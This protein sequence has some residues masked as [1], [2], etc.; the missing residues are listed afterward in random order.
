MN[1]SKRIDKI[2]IGI[3]L[4]MFGVTILGTAINSEA[5]LGHMWGAVNSIYNSAGWFL[6][7]MTLIC[8]IFVLYFLFSRAGDIKIGGEDAEPEFSKVTWWSISLCAGMGMGIVFWPAAECIEYAVRPAAGAH[9]AAGSHAAYLWAEAQTLNH[10]VITLYA[11]Y[12]AV[13]VVAT[14]TYHNLKQPFSVTASLYPTFG[15]KVYKYRSVIDG[16]VT[17]ALVGGVAGSF[18]YGVMQVGNGLEQI[19][20]IKVSNGLYITI[21]CVISV[22]FICSAMSGLKK[23]ITWLSNQNSRLFV[24]ILLFVIMTGPTVYSLNMGVESLGNLLSNFFEYITFTEPEVTGEKW[25]IGWNWLWYIDYFIFAPTTA[26]FL[27]RLS[28]GR[29]VREFVTINFVLPGAFCMI[30]TWFFGGL[31]S[32][33]QRTGIMDLNAVIQNEGYEAV[34][35][36]ILDTLPL[37]NII[38]VIMLLIVCVS[39]ITM[40]DSA[41]TTIAKMSMKPEKEFDGE[42]TEAPGAVRLFWGV[43][44]LVITIIFVLIGGL[45]GCKAIKLLVGVPILILESVVVVGFWIKMLKHKI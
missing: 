42:D 10:W 34:M 41:I 16:I 13:G 25:S 44:T 40:T 35:L 30:W 6:N 19:F 27:A 14:I 31:A 45:D 38:K 1:K 28:K 21:T 39:F 18:G 23:G 4:A 26:L 11:V 5:F 29:T 15:D 20:G 7:I 36:R 9:I 24:G 8:V 32:H 3:S 2:V 12:V 37:A 22:I 33:I 43:I 17:F